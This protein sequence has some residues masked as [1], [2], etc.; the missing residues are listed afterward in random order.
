MTRSELHA[1]V[2]R[3]SDAEVDTAA[4]LLDAYH[5]GDRAMI[6]ALTAP[7]EPAEAFERRALAEAATTP[8]TGISLEEYEAKNGLA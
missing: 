7:V 3:L 6:Q 5:R 8:G 4:A 1:L 2:D